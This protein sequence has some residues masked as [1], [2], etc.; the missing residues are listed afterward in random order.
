MLGSQTQASCRSVWPKWKL[1]MLTH[2]GSLSME[3][4]RICASACYASERQ[5][6]ELC[7]N[8]VFEGWG[9][10]SPPFCKHLHIATDSF[11]GSL[12]DL[13][14]GHSCPHQPPQ[15]YDQTDMWTW[16]PS[17]AQRGSSS[18]CISVTLPLNDFPSQKL[19]RLFKGRV[20]PPQIK[21]LK[22]NI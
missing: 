3:F 17:P 2:S 22:G 19:L 15:A 20:I 8:S 14:P 4:W 9:W 5:C 13:D 6:G 18:N 1:L 16:P 7:L 10:G 12:Q 11:P 21:S